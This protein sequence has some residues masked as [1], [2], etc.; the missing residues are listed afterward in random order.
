MD[1]VTCDTCGQPVES[2]V[3]HTD[4]QGLIRPGP[5]DF[6]LQPCGHRSTATYPFGS[7]GLSGVAIKDRP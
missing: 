4:Q 3:L 1:A 7:E 6:E 5:Q 2:F